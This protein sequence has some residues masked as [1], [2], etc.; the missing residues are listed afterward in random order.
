MRK[1]WTKDEENKLR[2]LVE[3]GTVYKSIADELGRTRKSIKEKCSK[4]GIGRKLRT[5]EQYIEELKEKCPTIEVLGVY[6]GASTRIL[7]KCLICGTEYLCLPQCKLRGYGHCGSSRNVGGIPIDKPAIVYLVFIPKYDLYKVGITSKTVKERMSDN[8][9]SK[10]ESILE[11]NFSTGIKAMMLEK[12]WKIN[13]KDYLI[14]TG[15]L[16]NGNTETFKI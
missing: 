13:L 16:K 5:Q 4:L 12:E 11:L 1:M 3:Q 15:L 9:I 7:H 2:T 14:N 10:Y 6:N 8:N